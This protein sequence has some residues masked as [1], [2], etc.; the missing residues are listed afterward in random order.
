MIRTG[1]VTAE[2]IP[3]TGVSP[4]AALSAA[5]SLLAGRTGAGLAALDAA[6]ARGADGVRAGG[7]AALGRI[8]VR[9]G[10]SLHIAGR[11]EQARADLRQA[12]AL[13]RRAGDVIWEARA[14]TAAALT[15]L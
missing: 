3:M 1:K 5:R 15:D 14:R 4:R 2:L 6:A 8:L 11:Y 9:R 7:P 13:T 10:G 12:I